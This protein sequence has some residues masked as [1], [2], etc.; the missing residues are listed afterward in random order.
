MTPYDR[1]VMEGVVAD[2]DGSPLFDMLTVDDNAFF[3]GDTTSEGHGEN[4]VD[5][6]VFFYAAA[7]EG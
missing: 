3:R 1:I 5:A 2:G 4:R 6:E 7:E